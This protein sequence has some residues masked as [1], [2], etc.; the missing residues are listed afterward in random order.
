MVNRYLIVNADDY[1]TDRERNKGILQS[2]REGIV[3]SV[4]VIANLPWEEKE[5][6]DLKKVAGTHVGI[7]LNLSKGLPLINQGKTLTST[8]GQFFIKQKAWRR[9]MLN[10]YDLKEVAMEFSAQIN[11]LKELGFTPDHIDGNNHIHVFPGIAPIV[12]RIAKDYNIPK[13]RLPLE[14]F[15]SWKNYVK[16]GAIKK[17]FIG[18]LSKSASLVFKAFGLRFPDHFSG[19]QF[20]RV[21][22]MDSIRAFMKNLP[23]GTNELMCHPG[24]NNHSDN[25]FSTGEREQ[26]LSIL[27]HPAVLDDIRHYNIKL[28]SYG[29]L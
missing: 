13:I 24:Y 7:H 29:G 2:F 4:S 26:E 15:Q 16:Q 20:P 3:T 6:K 5:I 23:E 17:Y 28:I 27:T 8:D 1:N 18:G 19:I 22:D 9:A 10:M 25:D 14:S 21:S 11:R 12:A